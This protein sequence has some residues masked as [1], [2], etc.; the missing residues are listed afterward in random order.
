V[1]LA[2][3][4]AMRYLPR[5]L[6]KKNYRLPRGV[7]ELLRIVPEIVPLRSVDHLKR[8]VF[9]RRTTLPSGIVNRVRRLTLAFCC[10]A[11]HKRWRGALLNQHNSPFGAPRAQD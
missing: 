6:R 10:G 7:G 8:R 9:L 1:T 5:Y 3:I 2:S 11:A 4:G